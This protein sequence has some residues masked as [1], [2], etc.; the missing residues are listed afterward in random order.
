MLPNIIILCLV[1]A[2]NL[3]QVIAFG[4]LRAHS[5]I[6]HKVWISHSDINLLFYAGGVPKC[7]RPCLQGIADSGST[8]LSFSNIVE[9]LGSVCKE[10]D[11]A[12]KCVKQAQC[13]D[14]AVYALLTQG[15]ETACANYPVIK[16][17]QPCLDQYANVVLQ[18][19]DSESELTMTL[20]QFLS[21]EDIKELAKS[22][23]NVTELIKYAGPI[24]SSGANFL[25][26]V[27]HQ[28][29][30]KCPGT[31]SFLVDVTLKPLQT[32]AEKWKDPFSPLK[33]MFGKHVPRQCHD[34]L[35]I[36]NLNRLK[37]FGTLPGKKQ[38]KWYGKGW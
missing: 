27:Q 7:I 6:Q 25:S 13:V 37:L 20:E 9:D 17:I 10:Y 22:G 36:D 31:G 33:K 29:N 16:I 38:G 18:G 24:C 35:D 32:V 23:G 5:E 12:T 8:L 15:L 30:S 28:L 21:N 34:L 14:E 26:C 1:L 2:G 4:Q 3:G 19:C 11:S